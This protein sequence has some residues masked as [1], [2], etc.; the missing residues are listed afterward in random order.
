MSFITDALTTGHQLLTT[1]REDQTIIQSIEETAHLMGDTLSRGFKIL[2]CG[3]GGSMCDSLHFAQ[4][5]TGRYRQDRP[6]ISAIS[7]GSGP[8]ITCTGN[9][10]GFDYIFSRDVQALG[11]KGD[12][13]LAISTSG[14]SK[15]VI[16]ATKEAKK[17]GIKIVGLL[18]KK[19][20]ALKNLVDIPIIVP[21]SLTDRIQEIHIKIIHI[22]IEGIERQLYPELY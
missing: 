16:L 7:L 4:E 13:L 15:N 22:L 14:N 9:D 1:V 18:G 12:C 8:H 19:G 6:A 10:Y 3:N 20:G 5:L 2:S 21:H 11:K 17:L